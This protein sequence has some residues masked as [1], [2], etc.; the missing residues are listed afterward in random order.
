MYLERTLSKTIKRTAQT[1]PA[2][3][4]T[5]PRQVGK[6]TLLQHAQ[7]TG[8]V[9]V[10]LDNPSIRALATEDPALFMQRYPYPV[11]ID[12]IQYAPN[13][14][15]HIKMEIDKHQQPAMFW[16]TGSQ[17]FHVMQG[18]AESLAGRIGILK[19][20]GLSLAEGNK[21]AEDALPFLPQ[22][23][24]M[25]KRLQHYQPVKLLNLYEKI[26]HGSF[27]Y[28]YL[29]KK[30]DW[31]IFYH[32]YVDTYL[33]RDIR[34]LAQVANEQAFFKFLRTAAARTAQLIN[35]ADMARDIGV[36]Q[37]TI[38]SW[39]SLLE[40]SGL[41]YILEPYSANLTKRLTK[42][43]KLYFL[44]TGLCSFLTN[45]HTPTTLESGAMSGAIFETFVVSEIIKSY[46]HNGKNA[47]LYFYR[48]HDKQEVDILIEQDGTLYPIEIKKKA[49]PDKGDSRS[50]GALEKLNL[51]IGHGAVICLSEDYLPI[52]ATVD[53]VPVG[54]L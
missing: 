37:V 27:P 16:L 7:K 19:L 18:V 32:S 50:F 46:W 52:S 12:E 54:L 26:W 11:L 22:P 39:L 3:L 35:Y 17:Q 14:L 29:N 43:A 30:V 47:P 10:T 38:K 20:L 23:N 13:L 4:I 31:E 28:L 6:T 8:R 44:D 15:P 33:K 41:V 49:N 53:A 24:L 2:L 36:S 51:P 5:G 45:W 48:D 34:D 40:T 42:T 9:Y 1:F 21:K 25:R